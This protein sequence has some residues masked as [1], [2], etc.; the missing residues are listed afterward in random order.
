MLKTNVDFS[1]PSHNPAYSRGVKVA[2]L[3]NDKLRAIASS[4]R[5]SFGLGDSEPFPVREMIEF[6]FL[7]IWPDYSFEIL[8]KEELGED[9]G[10][11]YPTIH[12]LCLREDVY[13]DLCKGLGYARYTGTHEGSHLIL[14]H[15]VAD[16]NEKQPETTFRYENAEWQ[17]DVLAE[18]LLMPLCGI[19]GMDKY[20]IADKFGVSVAAAQVR[21]E[22]VSKQRE[23]KRAQFV[24]VPS[25]K[26][27][28][29]APLAIPP[30]PFPL[31]RC[32]ERTAPHPAI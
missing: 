20:E 19:V 25:P 1:K 15:G 10:R 29:T 18:E 28:T 9:L 30:N 8:G 24:S 2:P 6:Y 17:A 3:S 23:R 5:L 32:V 4:V 31:K 22:R 16:P 7:P 14:A 12:R 21:I 13:S 26:L 27:S 11:T